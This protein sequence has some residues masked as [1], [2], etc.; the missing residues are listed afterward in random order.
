MRVEDLMTTAVVTLHE[1]DTIG[2]ANVEMKLGDMRHLPV[3][4]S[5]NRLVGIVSD[6]DI[7]R[8]LGRT[9]RRVSIPVA[10]MMTRN[11][12]TVPPGASA[13]TAVRL[14]LDNKI[15]A[16]PVVS[17]E[18]TIV[19]IVTSTDFLNLAYRMLIAK[20]HQT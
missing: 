3:V 17:E 9:E 1:T 13:H 10:K 20:T 2:H 14:M 11:T 18:Q 7:Y 12:I 16:L 15:D 5:K 8:A 19:G 6:R 4:D